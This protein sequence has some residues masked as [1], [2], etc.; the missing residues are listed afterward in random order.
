[1]LG[2]ANE[3]TCAS[4]APIVHR[5]G[6]PLWHAPRAVRLA[7]TRSGTRAEA[8]HS[9]ADEAPRGRQA[10]SSCTSTA[11]IIIGANVRTD[12]RADHKEFRVSIKERSVLGAVTV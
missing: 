5:N 3:P 6:F 4:A 11:A 12:L 10:R 9:A 7:G 1:M 2:G 8:L